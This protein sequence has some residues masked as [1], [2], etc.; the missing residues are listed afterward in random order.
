MCKFDYWWLTDEN[1]SYPFFAN[2]EV[3]DINNNMQRYVYEGFNEFPTIS[4]GVGK[5]QSGTITAILMDNFLTVNTSVAYRD[6]VMKFI[7][8][9]KPKYMKNPDGDI[10]MVDTRV[11]K[12]KIF[13]ETVQNLSQ[14]T[15][16]WTEIAKVDK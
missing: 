9:K 15:F 5:Y 6:S 2:L 4:Y 16:D 12:Y 1:E 11:S 8:N 13:T 10:W 14:V 7:N 3:S